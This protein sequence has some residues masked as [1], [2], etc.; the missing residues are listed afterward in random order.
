MTE[1]ETIQLVVLETDSVT[2]N[3]LVTVGLLRVAF[4]EFEQRFERKLEDKFHHYIGVIMED[5]RKN[6]L[7]IIE[8]MNMRFEAIERYIKGN[9]EDKVEINHRLNRLESKVLI[10]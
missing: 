8:N 9:E 3:T 10:A 6:T 1:R 7:L 4:E 2:D 5:N